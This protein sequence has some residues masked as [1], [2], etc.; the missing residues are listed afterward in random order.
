MYAVFLS[1]ERVFSMIAQ[2][3]AMM[4]LVPSFL[5]KR[6]VIEDPKLIHYIHIG[7]SN[8]LMTGSQ[9]H[10]CEESSR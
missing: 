5:E 3:V 4:D 9:F 1:R 6:M 7:L 2:T 10:P 8:C